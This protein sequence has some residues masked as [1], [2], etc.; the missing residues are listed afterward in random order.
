MEIKEVNSSLQLMDGTSRKMNERKIEK[1]ILIYVR[2][3]RRK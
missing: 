1:F 2:T 3:Y